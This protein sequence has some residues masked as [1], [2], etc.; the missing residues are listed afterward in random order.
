MDSQLYEII[1][2]IIFL[3][4]A[5]YLSAAE[6]AIAS[7]GSQKL[8]ELRE[9]NDKTFPLF[10]SIKQDANAFFGT[11]QISTNISLI[12]ASVLAFIIAIRLIN[13]LF[14]DSEI[15]ILNQ[16]SKLLSVIIA[17]VAVS[18]L[19]MV[20][21]ILIPKVL[22]FK[23]A[24]PIGKTSIRSL[25]LLTAL[26]KYPVR[27]VTYISNIL[28]IPF[29]EKTNFSQTRISEDE[30]RI[31]ISEGVKSGSIN[32]TEKEII[33]NIFEFNDLKAN[34]VMVP[35][36]EMVAV[37]INDDDQENAKRIIKSGHSLIPVFE[38]SLD[39]IIGVIHTKDYMRSFVEAVSVSIKG[40]IRPAYFIPETKL[41][42]GVLKE[43]Q[44]RGERIAIVTD[45][46][47]GTEGIITMEDILEEIVGELKDNT[48]MEVKEFTR[49]PDGKYYILGSMSIDDFN[50]SFTMPVA[51]SEEYNTVAGF[52]ADR[53]GKILNSGEV[54][55][56][57]NLTFELIKKI[58]QK[59]VQFRVYSDD[60]SF[61]EKK[62]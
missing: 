8:E 50:E 49:L 58:R 12:A 52:I 6:I 7:F 13:P 62:L 2:F 43:M 31:L 26:F 41:I 3:I 5:G 32:E 48:K 35:R 21:G 10:E 37:D 9:K 61:G 25:I 38:G 54:Y 24:E 19:T 22:G 47:G 36:T 16:Y 57:E 4:L 39:N 40:L 28:L 30:I 45:E 46:Y 20:F 17:I 60:G 53:T 33:E 51:T 42:S 15:P 27:L 14:T 44:K 11:I 55:K 1:F 56:Y 18:F 29:K 34:E 59:M 23:Y